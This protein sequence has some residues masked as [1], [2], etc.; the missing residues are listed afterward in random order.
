VLY[1]VFA[2]VIYLRNVGILVQLGFCATG[3]ARVDA[4][5]RSKSD[6]G[7]NT[8]FLDGLSHARKSLTAQALCMVRPASDRWESKRQT[9]VLGA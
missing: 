8:L 7:T 3:C 2:G 4:G 1:V 5:R 9:K 6:K